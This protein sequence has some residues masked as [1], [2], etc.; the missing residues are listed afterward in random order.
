MREHEYLLPDSQ[1][2]QWCRH[3]GCLW[4]AQMNA[5][6]VERPAAADT[7]P[8]R[9]VR[10]LDD[11]DAIHARLAE[12]RKE[13]DDALAADIVAETAPSAMA[14]NDCCCY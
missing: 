3:C 2:R 9:R 6:C 13:Q 7:A 1:N 8:R 11:I 5:T 14:L 12:L 10:A 4:H